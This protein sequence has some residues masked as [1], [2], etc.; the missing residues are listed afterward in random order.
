LV[1]IESKSVASARQSVV[2]TTELRAA[3]SEIADDKT[4]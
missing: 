1:V 3:L 2:L 4:A